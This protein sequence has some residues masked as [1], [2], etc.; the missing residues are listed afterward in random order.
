MSKIIKSIV[1][2]Y[3]NFKN[4]NTKKYNKNITIKLKEAK[5]KDGN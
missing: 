2:G 3:V 4:S 1:F 5:K